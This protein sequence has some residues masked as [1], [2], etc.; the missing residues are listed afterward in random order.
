[1]VYRKLDEY[2]EL[3]RRAGA[4]ESVEAGGLGGSL[5]RGI[6]YDSRDDMES[7]LFVCKGA[8]FSEKYLAEAMS[9][10]A[11]AYVSEKAHGGQAG[12]WPRVVVNDVR[13]AMALIANSYYGESWRRLRLTGITGTKGKSTT[14][15]YLKSVLDD[16]MAATGGAPTAIMS[17]IRNYDGVI[18]EESHLTT[19]E[20]FEL[21]R[22]LDNAAS[23]NLRYLSMEVSSQALKYGR[24]MGV[25]FDV[26]CFLNIDTDHISDAEHSDY[27]DYLASKMSIF[28]QCGRA[29]VNLGC[30]DAER[31]LEAARAASEVVSFGLDERADVMVYDLRP[32]DSGISFRTRVRDV[33]GNN[34]DEEFKISMGGLF[35]VE[36]AAAAIGAALCLGAP[37]EHVR[38][39]L[40]K[41]RVPG[42][43]EVFRG[44]GKT[45]IVDYAHNRLSFETLFKSVKREYPG[46]KICI[47]FGCTGSK[48]PGRR[49]E[50]GTLAGEHAD[51]VILT[52]DDPGYE[53][54]LD[55]C[56]EIESYLG[57]GPRR[58]IITDRAEAVR[59][60]IEGAGPDWVTL[61]V[62]KGTET[63]QKRGPD[64][65][66]T[67]SDV[68]VVREYGLL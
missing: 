8:H 23:K 39:G 26:A 32:L 36:N 50:M 6:S 9:K 18:D 54:T 42:R 60:A 27:E 55:I 41:A 68:E 65:V 15:Y 29:C 64:F 62:G 40:L 47:V 31:V 35:N 4:L 3:L 21:H 13:K 57:A 5:V 19:Q 53:T 44:E 30:R 33:C 46:K 7:S 67:K 1:M 25:E 59:R 66:P 17:G 34:F 56:R 20:T 24:T 16:W 43:M 51:R 14:T 45:V 49:Q 58:E 48:A 37:A 63:R 38:N 10:G 28:S 52:E 22:H 12:D 11:L 2:V 61:V